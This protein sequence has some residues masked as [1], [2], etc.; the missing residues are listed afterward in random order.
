MP[1]FHISPF[2]IDLSRGAALVDTNVLF[3]AFST[4]D[5]KHQNASEFVFEF[6]EGELLVPIPVVMN[7]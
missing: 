5:P 6:W 7:M 2:E 4:D 3:A 1:I